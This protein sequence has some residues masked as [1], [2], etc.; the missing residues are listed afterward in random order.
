VR[1][2][3]RTLGAAA[4]FLFGLVTCGPGGPAPTSDADCR[5]HSGCRQNG[6][7]TFNRSTKKCV[8]GSNQDCADSVICGTQNRC[9][10]VGDSCG[11]E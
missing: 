6:Q 4:V 10:Q 11:T 1:R 2:A 3:L 5:K 9:K 8:V 7:C